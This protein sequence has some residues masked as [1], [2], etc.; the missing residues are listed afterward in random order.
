MGPWTLRQLV[1]GR[2]GAAA[3]TH[4]VSVQAELQA[5]DGSCHLCLW[6]LLRPWGVRAMWGQPAGAPPD[7]HTQ[8]SL[9]FNPGWRPPFQ[10]WAGRGAVTWQDGV[11]CPCPR[12]PGPG[13]RVCSPVGSLR[14]VPCVSEWTRA[15]GQGAPLRQGA[16][17]GSDLPSAPPPPGTPGSWPPP[18]PLRGHTVGTQRTGRGQPG[19]GWVPGAPGRKELGRD[20]PAPWVRTRRRGHPGGPRS[21]GKPAWGR[22]FGVRCPLLTWP[23][24]SMDSGPGPSSAAPE[25]SLGVKGPEGAQGFGA[26]PRARWE[27]GRPRAAR[28]ALGTW[29]GQAGTHSVV[30][31]ASAAA[32]PLSGGAYPEAAGG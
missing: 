32:G 1:L 30:H 10:V 18:E 15:W 9:I 12:C 14:R 2:R 16:F 17:G 24:Q 20:G 31:T 5:P 4:G 11:G 21:S 23:P 25:A 26:E 7:S 27:A 19:W 13:L 22:G 28:A 8:E 29:R 6:A 3:P